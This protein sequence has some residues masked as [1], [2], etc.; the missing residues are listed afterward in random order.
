MTSRAF[1]AG[2]QIFLAGLASTISAG[3]WAQ[4]AVPQSKPGL[5]SGWIDCPTNGFNTAMAGA[6]AGDK[7]EL[8]GKDAS[9]TM[10][11]AG[12]KAEV[13]VQIISS[14]TAR[15][16]IGGT[17]RDNKFTATG[18]LARRPTAYNDTCT[19]SLAGPA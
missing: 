3:A 16:T 12:D 15:G 6:P 4:D 19:I 18:H 11:I 13:Y 1:K 14:V 17:I 2:R 8:K 5:W 10:K 7:V 9:M